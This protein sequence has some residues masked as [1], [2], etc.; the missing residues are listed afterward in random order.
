[1]IVIKRIVMVLDSLL[2]VLC[3][4][5][6]NRWTIRMNDYRYPDLLQPLEDVNFHPLYHSYS[7][8]FFKR[9]YFHG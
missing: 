5:L 6:V 8:I 3:S 4:G 9:E 7:L 1:M 2:L